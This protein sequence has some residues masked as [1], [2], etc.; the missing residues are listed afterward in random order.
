MAGH[1]PVIISAEGRVSGAYQFA[2]SRWR[3]IAAS[4]GCKVMERNPQQRPEMTRSS[5]SPLAHGF[6]DLGSRQLS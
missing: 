6:S 1:S 3:E 4:K 5:H 2:A